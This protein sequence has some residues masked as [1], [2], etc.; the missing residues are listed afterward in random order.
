M[1]RRLCCCVA[2]PGLCVAHG[3][4]FSECSTEAALFYNIGE[5]GNARDGTGADCCLTGLPGGYLLRQLGAVASICGSG[6]ACQWLDNEGSDSCVWVLYI[7]SA[8]EAYVFQYFPDVATATNIIVWKA[9]TGYDPLCPSIFTYYPDHPLD[10]PP[11]DCSWYHK[12]CVGGNNGCCDDERVE[13]MPIALD[14]SF[15]YCCGDSANLSANFSLT[16][17]SGT[18][19]WE[20]GFT[21]CSTTFAFTL[22][23]ICG[24]ST[25]CGGAPPT[26]C[27]SATVTAG[28]ISDE[29]GVEN[30][31]C[32]PFEGEALFPTLMVNL[33]ICSAEGLSGGLLTFE[34]PA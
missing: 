32:E 23:C 12:L 5:Y 11:A 21:A 30:C 9:D 22:R 34:E 3:T 6:N 4:S 33:G 10:N 15:T 7:C 17:N 25:G 1:S 31:I 20:G 2:C 24:P 13:M 18:G 16:W 28:V 29:Q 19:R 14:A 27:Y 26:H 8:T